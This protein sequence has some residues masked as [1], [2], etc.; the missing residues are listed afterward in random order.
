MIPRRFERPAILILLL[1]AAY[2]RIQDLQVLPLGFSDEETEQLLIMDRIQGG[3]VRVFFPLE[4]GRP[5]GHEGF[6]ALLNASLTRLVGDGL[7]GYRLLGLYSSLLA[8]ACF[9]WAVK[10]LLGRG[11][12]LTATGVML[13]SIW[14]LILARNVIPL[15]L[16][17][18]NLSASLAA[19]VWAYRLY[20]PIGPTPPQ[21]MRFTILGFILSAAVY[22]HYSGALL[23]IWLI[24]F[25]LFM[26]RSNQ[27]VSRQVWS[28]SIFCITLVL[29]L[30]LPYLISVVRN[31][32]QTSWQSLWDQ[33]HRGPWD[34][35]ESLFYTFFG[36][37]FR[38]DTDPSHNVP[39]WPLLSPLWFM[40]A[41][42]GLYFAA[43]RW[44]EPGYALLLGLGIISLGPALWIRDGVNFE[45]LLM[46]QSG[47]FI[48][49]GLG[50]YYAAQFVRL[51]GLRGGWQGVAA[52]AMLSFLWTA[53]QAQTQF[54]EGWPGR[55]DVQIIYH[56]DVA[57]LAHYLD[58]SPDDS[59]VLFCVSRLY[60]E[61]ESTTGAREFSEVY[62]AQKMMHREGLPL[63]FAICRSSIV[64]SKGGEPMRVAL[65]NARSLNEAPAVIRA[66]FSQMSP[67]GAAI[68]G[69]GSISS[70]E[71]EMALAELGGQ[72]PDLSPLRYVDT[73]GSVY[74]PI[75]FGRNLTL[76]GYVL[77]PADTYAP[78]DVIA[79]STYWRI[80]GEPPSRLG[81]FTRLQGELG[82][83]PITET[84]ALDLLPGDLRDRDIFIQTNFMSLPAD[85]PPGEYYLTLGVYDNNPL[86]QI[87]VFNP[88]ATQ[89]RGTYLIVDLPI[90][91]G[92]P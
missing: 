84:N 67:S 53:Y 12:A 80:D 3:E 32:D 68:L 56:S 90:I 76:L 87:N 26:W 69:Q 81:V 50:T 41:G 85:L 14:G 8:L 18:L 17:P 24:G 19:V 11:V 72:L 27:P 16:V 33:H 29:I 42:V 22:T 60:H 39:G 30:C 59:P 28:S 54:L 62:L 9:F 48:L 1:M 25:I 74:P 71:A 44:R 43:P 75:R 51:S 2:L 4:S 73:G 55:D 57:G 78:N 6:Y 92:P 77:P 34:F 70:L 79:L 5:G 88:A 31:P 37:G 83:S 89:E 86:N 23:V 20:E 36:L 15:S 63:R 7:L 65:A 40:L 61:S 49:A 58:T 13:T 47:L 21:T 45:A 46:L 35:F 64:F 82:Q 66:W 52:L 10:G 91:V 38:G